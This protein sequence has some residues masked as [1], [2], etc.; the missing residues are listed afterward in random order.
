MAVGAD[1][2]HADLGTGEAR[3]FR[4]LLGSLR[5]AP[6]EVVSEPGEHVT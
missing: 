3:R 6:G 5:K 4:G 2:C 1:G